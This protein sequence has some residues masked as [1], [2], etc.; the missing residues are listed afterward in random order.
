MVAQHWDDVS[1]VVKTISGEVKEAKAQAEAEAKK[2]AEAAAKATDGLEKVRSRLLDRG[3]C[4]TVSCVQVAITD[5]EGIVK[6]IISSGQGKS[7]VT[8]AKVKAHYTGR[9]M[10]G[11]VFDSSV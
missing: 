6:H 5:D 3:S 1:A 7:P 2:Q 8:G 4:V 11:S 10:D 9:L